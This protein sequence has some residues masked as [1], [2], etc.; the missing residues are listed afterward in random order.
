MSSFCF[1]S[2]SHV[3]VAASRLT[4]SGAFQRYSY[5][6]PCSALAHRR[7]ARRVAHHFQTHVDDFTIITGITGTMRLLRRGSFRC[8]G[9]IAALFTARYCRHV[10]TLAVARIKQPSLRIR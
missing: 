5:F 3:A 7:H 8:D 1:T 9:H 4:R 6:M 10:V 2:S